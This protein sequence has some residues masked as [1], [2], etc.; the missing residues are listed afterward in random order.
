MPELP[1]IPGLPSGG[2]KMPGL[3]GPIQEVL[4]KLKGPGAAT[5]RDAGSIY[6]KQMLGGFGGPVSEMDLSKDS[7]LELQKAIQRA[8]KRTGSEIRKVEG[9]IQK[10]KGMGAK[11]GN[12]ALERQKSFLEKLKKGGIRVQY[13]DYADE[14]GQMSESAKN[15]KNI[16]GQFW[17]YER[18]KKQ[19]GGYRVEDKYDFDMFK[20]KVK[21]PKTGKMGERDFTKGELWNEGFLGKGKTTQQRL[22]ALYLLNPL[23]GKGDVDM[24]LGGKRT[25]AESWG[26]S[27]SK[28]L[29]GGMLGVSGKPKDKNTKA[30]EAKR[31]W[32]DKAGWFGGGSRVSQEKA[33]QAQIARSKPKALP[34]KPPKKPTV[35]MQGQSAVTMYSKNDPRR[36]NTRTT[37]PSFSATNP[38]A[39]NSKA[40]VLNVRGGK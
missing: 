27:G 19:G 15:A 29:L 24:V 38:K 3:P 14:K 21:D 4:D 33:K 30:L 17:A 37:T 26:L 9:E 8:K 28:T 22:Q 32:W 31:P 16:L 1:K 40:K 36:K 5:Y 12:P 25:A 39:S 20:K 11:D 34:V 23:R 10:L 7:R 13:T 2:I 35:I 18:D 6:A